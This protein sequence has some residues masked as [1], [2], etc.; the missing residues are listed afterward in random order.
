ML[1]EI[2]NTIRAVRA[3]RADPEGV[4]T[5]VRSFDAITELLGRGD[6]TMVRRMNESESGRAV[7]RERPDVLALVSNRAWLAGLPDGER[8]DAL[9]FD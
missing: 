6:A 8:R 9:A 3:H 5:A 1:R 2:V 7:M 4:T